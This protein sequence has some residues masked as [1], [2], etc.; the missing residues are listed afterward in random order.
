MDRRAPSDPVAGPR[1]SSRTTATCPDPPRFATSQLRRTGITDGR[2]LCLSLCY[3]LLQ[4][5][6]LSSDCPLFSRC[7]NTSFSDRNSHVTVLEEVARSRIAGWRRVRH[8][9]INSEVSALN[10]SAANK[11]TSGTST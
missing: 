2:W 1:D 5:H 9:R 7:C 11:G 3:S 6:L 4:L 10:T 8:L